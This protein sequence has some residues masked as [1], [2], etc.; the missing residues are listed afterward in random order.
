MMIYG[1]MGH[2]DG[3]EGF[4]KWPSVG[5]AARVIYLYIGHADM[6][7]IIKNTAVISNRDKEKAPLHACRRRRHYIMAYYLFIHTL[8]A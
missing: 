6:I 5:M 8:Y 4:V 3:R 7:C 2:A 1:W